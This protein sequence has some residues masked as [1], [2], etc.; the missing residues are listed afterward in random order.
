M[1]YGLMHTYFIK[2]LFV[3]ISCKGCFQFF[4]FTPNLNEL[5]LEGFI[6]LLEH[7]QNLSQ[8]PFPLFKTEQDSPHLFSG[9]YCQS[10]ISGSET[11]DLLCSVW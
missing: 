4:Y 5:T 10:F 9:I 1:V 3:F 11:A 6:N 2:M 8:L 7:A